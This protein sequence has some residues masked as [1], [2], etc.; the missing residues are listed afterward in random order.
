MNY[1]IFLFRF[2]SSVSLFHAVEKYR[3][4]LFLAECIVNVFQMDV[5]K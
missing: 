4:L 2:F 1:S 3:M 5:V